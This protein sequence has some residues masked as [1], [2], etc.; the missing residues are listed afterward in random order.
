MGNK[1]GFS[2]IIVIL[3]IGIIAIG[4]GLVYYNLSIGPVDKNDNNEIT[5]NIPVG[6]TAY[7]IVEI[8]NNNGLVNDKLVAK[9]FLKLNS[10]YSLKANTYIF[11]KSMGLEEMFNIINGENSSYVSNEKLTIIE[12]STLNDTADNVAKLLGI[13]KEEVLDKWKD[14]DYL[15]TLI[16]KYWFLTDEILQE[17]IMFP[18]EGYLYPET[19]LFSKADLSIENIT[20]IVLNHTDKILS[21]IKDEI[22]N[23]GYTVH[24]FLSLASVINGESMNNE[25]Q[26]IIAGVFVNRLNNDM[27]LQSDITV[28][29]ALQEKRVNVSLEDLKVDSKYNTYKYKGLPIGPVGAT[30][31]ST[32]ENT[33][34]YTKSDYLYFFA[35]KEGKVIYSKTYEEHKKVTEENLWY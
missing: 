22:E 17:G 10:F 20:S 5:V 13:S 4:S 28:L 26:P 34:N 18:L 27:P 29:Y 7:D 16:E 12:G 19:Y 11:N 3:I 14:K 1:K 23:S 30:P 32:M 21:E 6:S 2:F 15:K 35:T 24:E 33:L 9:L 31:K 8:L 25:D